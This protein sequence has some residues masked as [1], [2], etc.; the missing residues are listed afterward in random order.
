MFGCS[1][2]MLFLLCLFAAWMYYVDGAFHLAMVSPTANARTKEERKM[3]PAEPGLING[4]DLEVLSADGRL[5]VRRAATKADYAQAAAFLSVA[6]AVLCF[7]LVRYAEFPHFSAWVSMVAL[8]LL[9]AGLCRCLFLAIRGP[10]TFVF[11][12]A[13][14]RICRNGR[15]LGKCSAVRWVLLKFGVKR[16]WGETKT[17][18]GVRRTTTREAVFGVYVEFA[19]GREVK[20]GGGLKTPLDGSGE[21]ALVLADYLHV[22]MVQNDLDRPV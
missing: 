10:D 6:V 5:I 13:A 15:L 4:A 20:I 12:S 2:G 22:E 14:D 17:P 8:A 11:D 7:L 19:D 3:G 9:G 18:L 16:T 1:C 21:L